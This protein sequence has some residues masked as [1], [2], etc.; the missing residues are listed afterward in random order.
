MFLPPYTACLSVCLVMGFDG[1]VFKLVK[2]SANVYD[3]YIYTNTYDT[4]KCIQAHTHT[5]TSM[6]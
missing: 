2:Y 1:C 4:R 5:R 6:L 3:T